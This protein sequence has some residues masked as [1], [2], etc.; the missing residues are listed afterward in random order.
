MT[1]ESHELWAQCLLNIE[2]RVLARSF[3]TWFRTTRASRFD[4]ESLVIEVQSAWSA[5]FVESNYL[6]LIQKVVKE[7]TELAPEIRF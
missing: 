4:S 6:T 7:E 2:R 1:L 3:D 5:D